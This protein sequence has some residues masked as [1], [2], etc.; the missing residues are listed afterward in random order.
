ML[1]CLA[2]AFVTKDKNSFEEMSGM[3]FLTPP[4]PSQ[5][6]MKENNENNIFM[7]TSLPCQNAEIDHALP[8]P[9]PGENCASLE[10]CSNTTDG[11]GGIDGNW[12]SQSQ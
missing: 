11:V 2:G 12:G 1:L 10:H 7:G 6:E 5:T 3:T 9:V 8:H 4:A